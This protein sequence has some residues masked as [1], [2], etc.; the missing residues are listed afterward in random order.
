MSYELD[1][2]QSA[3][4]AIIEANFILWVILGCL[5]VSVIAVYILDFILNPVFYLKKLD[6]ILGAI[7]KNVADFFSFVASRP[8]AIV[9][10]LLGSWA[11]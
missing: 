6:K 11:K 9:K 2:L 5:V 7:E 1:L 4:N 8:Q 3:T 10:S